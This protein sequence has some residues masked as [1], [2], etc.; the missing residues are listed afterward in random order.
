MV[1]TRDGIVQVLDLDLRGKFDP[2]FAVKLDTTV[3][4][5]VEFANDA[6]DIYVFGFYDGQ[7]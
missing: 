3:P 5:A 6:L 1:G 4:K 7:V 2:V